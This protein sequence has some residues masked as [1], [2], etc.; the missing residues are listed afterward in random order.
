MHR[1]PKIVILSRKSNTVRSPYALIRGATARR[2]TGRAPNV[3]IYSF[4]FSISVLRGGKGVGGA[5]HS[6]TLVQI[7]YADIRTRIVMDFSRRERHVDVSCE[8]DL[9]SFWPDLE[10]NTTGITIILQFD[11]L[12]YVIWRVPAKFYE[13]P[14]NSFSVIALRTNEIAWKITWKKKSKTTCQFTYAQSQWRNLTWI[15]IWINF[16]PGEFEKN[17]L[18]GKIFHQTLRSKKS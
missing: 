8:G 17:G 9:E 12:R 11:R 3:L 10:I 16:P 18:K 6:K 15:K 14:I 13:F 4:L 7:T 5:L 2:K 1:D